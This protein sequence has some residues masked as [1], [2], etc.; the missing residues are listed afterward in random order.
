MLPMPI[1]SLSA[2]Y[3][4]AHVY[5]KRLMTSAARLSLPLT[6]TSR[7]LYSC[8]LMHHHDPFV[9]HLLGLHVYQRLVVC[10]DL[11]KPAT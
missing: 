8:R 9:G 5:A 6:E 2:A 11:K 10:V 1:L 4:Y 7:N 3:F